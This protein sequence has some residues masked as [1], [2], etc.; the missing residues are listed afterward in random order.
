MKIM[1]LLLFIHITTFVV[2]NWLY[3][4]SSDMVRSCLDANYKLNRTFHVITH[5]LLAKDELNLKVTEAIHN[6][7]DYMS[8][9]KNKEINT[10]DNLNKDKPN[11]LEAY[12]KSFNY[13]YAKKKGID[14]FDCYCERKIFKEI[15]KID[16]IAEGIS[17]KKQIKWFI[18]KKYGLRF[19]LLFL[20][21]LIGIIIP[22]LNEYGGGDTVANCTV[23]GHDDISGGNVKKSLLHIIEDTFPLSNIYFTFIIV[24]GIITFFASIYILTKIIKYDELK[25]GIRII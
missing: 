12:K 6:N 7:E 18:Y 3:N 13:R 16:K 17:K 21:P 20:F 4:P 2:L 22:I 25:K 9:K 8:V 11:K 15:E 24:L 5:R 23:P 10:Y 1:K 14:K 19:I